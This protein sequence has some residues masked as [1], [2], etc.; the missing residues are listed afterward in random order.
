M[1]IAELERF[2]ADLQSRP[3]LRAGAG[4][5]QAA[6][7]REALLEHV[8]AF[9]AREGYAFTVDEARKH[10][11]VQGAAS[12]GELSDAELDGMAGGQ[13]LSLDLAQEVVWYTFTPPPQRP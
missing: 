3:A 10:M 9:A 1:S 11:K 8:V 13:G 7:T 4:K 6:Q 2:I 5:A 12:G